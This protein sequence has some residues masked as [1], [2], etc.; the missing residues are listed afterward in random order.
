MPAT[1]RLRRAALAASLCSAVALGATACGPFSGGTNDAAAPAGPF[2]GLSGPQILDKAVDTTKTATSLHLA[3]DVRTTDGP[4]KSSVST[5]LQGQCTGTMAI[6][7]TGTAELVRPADK[8]V[9]LRFDEALLK[10]QVKGES[11]DV[12]KAV[13]KELKGRWMKT[14]AKDPDAKDMLDL[15]DLKAL[16]ADFEQTSRGT[17]QGEETT[18]DGR[19]ALVLRQTLGGEKS[20][21][22]VATEGKPYLLKVVTTGGRE[23]GTIALSDFD[24]PVV[25]KAPAKKDVVDEKS[26]G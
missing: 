4:M 16:L 2:G 6:G 17:V 3:I 11:P 8:A 13:L 26:L 19:R 1:A 18:L 22:Y 20:T 14:D 10:E 5:D 7:A 21:F 24:R 12:Q 15:C 9:Y 23:P 25:A